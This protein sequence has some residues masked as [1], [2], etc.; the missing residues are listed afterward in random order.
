M[1]KSTVTIT[2]IVVVGLGG[3]MFAANMMLTPL[4]QD[5]EAAKEVEGE[6]RNLGWLAEGTKVRALS[7]K[8]GGEERLFKEKEWGVTV[9]LSPHVD[10]F[11]SEGRLVNLAQRVVQTV[12][13]KG[14]R[15]KGIR[16]VEIALDYNDEDVIRTLYVLDPET[17]RWSNRKP[18]LPGRWQ[19]EGGFP[20]E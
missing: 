8:G 2:T 6:L 17:A 18:R 19:P 14:A 1:R 10:V 7:L 11:T 12:A 3:L 20:A 13:E 5:A 9:R 15:G 4:K 16:W